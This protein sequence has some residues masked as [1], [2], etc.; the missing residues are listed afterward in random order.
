LG[1]GALINRAAPTS[2]GYF[3]RCAASL[4]AL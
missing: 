4:I 1:R 2:D 3:V